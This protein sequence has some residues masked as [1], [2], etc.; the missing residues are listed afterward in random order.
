MAIWATHPGRL[1]VDNTSANADANAN[2]SEIN[3]FSF[4]ILTK[5][6]KVVGLP[7]SMLPPRFPVQYQ[8]EVRIGDPIQSMFLSSAY[9]AFSIIFALL[10]VEH[11]W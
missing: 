4:H 5:M 10:C 6:S 1:P 2:A 9:A 11:G 3:I 7:R 8:P